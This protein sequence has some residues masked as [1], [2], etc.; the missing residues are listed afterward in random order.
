MSKRFLVVKSIELRLLVLQTIAEICLLAIEQPAYKWQDFNTGF[1]MELGITAL[2]CAVSALP[3]NG[4]SRYLTESQSVKSC[5]LNHSSNEV[6]VMEMERSP[7][8]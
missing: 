1:C 3:V 7:P 4:N 8:G 6:S 5:G 2:R